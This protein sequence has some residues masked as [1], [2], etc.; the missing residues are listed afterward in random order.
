MIILAC[1]AGAPVGLDRVPEVPVGIA[2][3][4]AVI[5]KAL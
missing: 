2:L 5:E 3:V 4:S 1:G